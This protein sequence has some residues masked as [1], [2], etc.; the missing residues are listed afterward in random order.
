METNAETWGRKH[1]CTVGHYVYLV[2]VKLMSYPQLLI[3]NLNTIIEICDSH[4]L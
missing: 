1:V 2:N 3:H 4:N